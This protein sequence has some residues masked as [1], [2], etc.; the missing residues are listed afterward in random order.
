MR[1]PV[2]RLEIARQ[3]KQE[4]LSGQYVNRN[5]LPVEPELA[6]QLGVTRKTLRGALDLLEKEGLLERIPGKGTFLPLRSG[7]DIGNLFLLLPCSDYFLKSDYQTKSIIRDILSGCLQEACLRKAHVIT[8]PLT[9]TNRIEDFDETILER[10]PDG[11]RIIF[12]SN[13]Y[14]PIFPL[15]LRKRFRIAHIHHLNY[16]NS[17]LKQAVEQ[18]VCCKADLAAGVG[19][20]LEHLAQ[21]GCSRIALAASFLD[22]EF[23]PL[24]SGYLRAL[25]HL[26]GSH[27][28]LLCDIGGV[29]EPP[30]AFVERLRN[31]QRETGFDALLFGLHDSPVLNFAH[32]LN[33]NFGLPE[34]TALVTLFPYDFNNKYTP[35]IPSV[36]FDY[37]SIGVFA[38]QSLFQDHYMPQEIV[39]SPNLELSAERAYACLGK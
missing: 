36:K 33:S 9:T 18:W 35:G 16:R 5:R 29:N 27:P 39:F 37:L 14:A 19:K 2:K 7:S 4:I 30:M 25:E 38:V 34:K 11:S 26:P 17:I 32:S 3:L 12:Y 28:P 24:K 1:M 13:W 21:Q 23:N 22:N 10:L 31:F 15:F 6:A 20:A 8:L